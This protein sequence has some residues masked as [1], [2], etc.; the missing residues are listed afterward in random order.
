MIFYPVSVAT[1]K[2]AGAMQRVPVVMAGLVPAIPRTTCRSE[3]GRNK[4]GHDGKA[5]GGDKPGH[6]RKDLSQNKCCS[7]A[8]L[9]P[10]RHGRRRPT[11]HGFREFS[12]ASHGWPACADHDVAQASVLDNDSLILP[13][14]QRG[15]PSAEFSF[16]ANRPWNGHQGRVAA[17][18]I[19]MSIVR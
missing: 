6:D 10:S 19:R 3:D 16:R 18:L 2:L 15:N 5:D 13:H 9:A 11:I 17:S 14:A 12:T 1:R 8:T 7:R 4:P